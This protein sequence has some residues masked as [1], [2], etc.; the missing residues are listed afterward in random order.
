MRVKVKQ[1]FSR[2]WWL[3]K[4]RETDVHRVAV[5]FWSGVSFVGLVSIS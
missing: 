2:Q 4:K 5:S 3:E 1:V